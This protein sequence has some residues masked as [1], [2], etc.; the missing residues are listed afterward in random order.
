MTVVV[1]WSPLDE[2]EIAY[3]ESA[4]STASLRLMVT[5]ASV[6]TSMASGRGTVLATVGPTSVTAATTLTEYDVEP[7]RLSA[8]KTPQSPWR[9]PGIA[10]DGIVA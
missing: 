1:L 10:A 7:E 9:V 6:A 2:Q 5:L 8:S 4:T 3:H